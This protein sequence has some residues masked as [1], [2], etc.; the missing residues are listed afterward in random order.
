VAL[1][2]I[3]VDVLLPFDCVRLPKAQQVS[4]KH[5]F[6]GDQDTLVV[7]LHTYI[8]KNNR[9]NSQ[10]NV[11]VAFR[12][13]LSEGLSDE[14]V[15]KTVPITALGQLRLGSVWK[16]GFCRSQAV[17]EEECFDVNFSL[18][19][20]RHTSFQNVEGPPYA[21]EKYPISMYRRKDRNQ[22][23]EFALA[24]EGRLL[25]PC[26]EFFYR[27]YGRSAEIKRVLTTYPWHGASEPHL[28][29]LFAYSSEPEEPG[30]MKVKLKKRLVLDDVLLLAHAKYDLYTEN[31]LK[32]IYSTIASEFDRLN[33]S[34]IF[35]KIQPWH[36]GKAK[37]KVRGLRL[38]AGDFL[39]LQIVG[40]S[41]PAGLV[42]QRDREDSRYDAGL[43]NDSQ[44][45]DEQIG[46]GIRRP[47]KAPF[48]VDLT[49]IEEPDFGSG[50]TEI[51][52]TEFEVVGKRRAVIDVR[53]DRARNG[54]GQSGSAASASVVSGGTPYG[55]GKGVGQ[56]SIHAKQVMQSL[57]MLRDMWNAM[58]HLQNQHP[59]LI[60]SVEWFT[61]EQGFRSGSEPEL[62]AL[63]PFRD[64]DDSVDAKT[65]NWLYY[66]VV[67][68]VPR[69][70]LVA[71]LQVQSKT[72]FVVELQRRARFKHQDD[73]LETLSEEA[74]K[75]FVFT[76][77]NE[78]SFL[79]WITKLLGE[80]RVVHGIVRKITGKCPGVAVA[81]SHKSSGYD[82]I[83]CHAAVVNALG[84]IGVS[85]SKISPSFE[86]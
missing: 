13:V 19:G 76:L 79:K 71:R 48:I 84:K 18:G 6:S 38:N 74:F 54:A 41:D 17:F 29:E 66:D 7:W 20:W 28:S 36:Q 3:E 31:V 61:F 64:S 69:G 67:G 2:L 63:T 21:W 24:G 70:V 11:R 25:V 39:A 9:A 15:Y 23:L 80:I 65:R 35:L 12:K 51:L 45:N 85:L 1:P 78:Q 72:I 30:I 49:G 10:P 47:K 37:L 32:R 27:C 58:L 56:A 5:V 77:D 83:S 4:L 26:L 33:S 59:T 57:G 73:G 44:V 68:K 46:G 52:D 75:G 62:V 16:D 60:Q 53:R 22:F 55:G 50:S 42:I 86:V 40:C 8:T 14:I 34:Y 82:E 81:F 43:S